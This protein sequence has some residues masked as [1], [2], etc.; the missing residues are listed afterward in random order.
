MIRSF[1]LMNSVASIRSRV[2]L[3][4]L[5]EFPGAL[6]LVG[7]LCKLV[8][9]ERSR[10]ALS[11]VFRRRVTIGAVRVAASAEIVTTAISVIVGPGRPVVPLLVGTWGLTFAAL[12]VLGRMR[13]A[14]VGC[15]C[16]GSAAAAPLGWG[17]ISIGLAFI[18]ICI[19]QTVKTSTPPIPHDHR[20]VATT[21][22]V[23]GVA[24]LR[25]FSTPIEILRP[26][27]Q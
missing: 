7:G 11:E 5:Y 17:S 20:I 12:G 18:A 21:I 6:L 16:F 23:L 22:I 13:R 24:F 26:D 3:T 27:D 15:G 10:I 9:P 1:F 25:F 2:L 19:Q 8:A 4:A 14:T